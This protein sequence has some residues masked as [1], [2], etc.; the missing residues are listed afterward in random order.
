LIGG[1]AAGISLIS[2]AATPTLRACQP[3][4]PHTLVSR[5][6]QA[7]DTILRAEDARIGE[8]VALPRSVRDIEAQANLLQKLNGNNRLV[9]RPR[10]D[11]NARPQD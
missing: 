5:A 6:A 8:L 2:R 4:F 9:W 1:Q 3:A 7:Q 10:R 11:S